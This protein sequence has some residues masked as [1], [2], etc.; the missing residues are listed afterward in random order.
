MINIP[1]SICTCKKCEKQS[2]FQLDWDTIRLPKNWRYRTRSW[3]ENN[4]PD[5]VEIVC[6]AC[7]EKM[8]ER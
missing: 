5:D 6:E 4:E 1:N 8:N 2:P 7:F 3:R